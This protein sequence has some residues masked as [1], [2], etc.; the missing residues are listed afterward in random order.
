MGNEE[1]LQLELDAMAAIGQALG[2]LSDHAARQRVLAWAAERFAVAVSAAPAAPG[3]TPTAAPVRPAADAGLSIDSLDDMFVE[4]PE[5]PADR[6]SDGRPLDVMLRS[7]ST[8]FQRFVDEW[9]G[10]TA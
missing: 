1:S 3:T 4:E 6:A 2:R 8:D 9:N 7:F 5:A 10:A